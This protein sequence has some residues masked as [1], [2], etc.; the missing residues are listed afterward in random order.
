MHRMQRISKPHLLPESF[1]PYVGFQALKAYEE[2][3]FDMMLKAFNETG[4][5]EKLTGLDQ[6]N[7]KGEG[8]LRSADWDE[9]DDM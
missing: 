3:G 2:Q 1:F 7:G 6:L 5:L 8:A 4:Y 9:D